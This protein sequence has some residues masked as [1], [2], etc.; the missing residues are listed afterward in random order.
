MKSH[1]AKKSSQKQSCR[2]AKQKVNDKGEGEGG[3]RQVNTNDMP[4]PRIQDLF[5]TQTKGRTK[6]NSMRMR[7]DSSTKERNQRYSQNIRLKPPNP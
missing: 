3:A 6:R 2:E 1:S 4:T 7:Q 5:Q